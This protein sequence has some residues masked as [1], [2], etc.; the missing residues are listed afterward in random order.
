ML[1]EHINYELI[2]A[3]SNECDSELTNFYRNH[4][5]INLKLSGIL[6]WSKLIFN[7]EEV[8]FSRNQIMKIV[9]MSIFAIVYRNGHINQIRSRAFLLNYLTLITNGRRKF[10][11]RKELK[12]I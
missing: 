6:N 9:T 4:Q 12:S 10:P 2:E 1:P 8:D 5:N 7:E 3:I 11:L